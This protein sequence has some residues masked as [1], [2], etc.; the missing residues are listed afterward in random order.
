MRRSGPA[1]RGDA[2]LRSRNLSTKSGR[3]PSCIS[4]LTPV[5]SPFN[6]APPPCVLQTRFDQLVLQSR[7]GSEHALCKLAPARMTG[8]PVPAAAISP[9]D[10]SAQ[11]HLVP[12]GHAPVRHTHCASIFRDWALN[13]SQQS[14]H[15]IHHALGPCLAVRQ[16]RRMMGA[17]CGANTSRRLLPS[18]PSGDPTVQFVS[19]TLQ[20]LS[21]RVELCTHTGADDREA[22]NR[23]HDLGASSSHALPPCSCKWPQFG[24]RTASDAQERRAEMC[25][26]S[27]STLEHVGYMPKH[28]LL[29]PP[30]HIS[31]TLK[32]PPCLRQLSTAI[33]SS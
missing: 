18:L 33:A 12:S 1:E 10:C 4:L 27:V 32:P 22:R 31:L 21:D 5:Y 6:M 8:I 28:T 17:C 26:S 7:T 20:L 25:C 23:V 14:V 3:H 19:L 29:P 9:N 13:I 16:G 11:N 2:G 30:P 15:L 24:K